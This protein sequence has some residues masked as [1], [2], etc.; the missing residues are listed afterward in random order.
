MRSLLRKTKELLNRREPFVLVVVTE[1]KGSAPRDAGAAMIVT[2]NGLFEG[3]VGGGAIE[4]HC[5]E[6]AKELLREEKSDRAHYTL[7]KDSAKDIGMICGGENRV[8]FQYFSP[9]EGEMLRNFSDDHVAMALFLDGTTPLLVSAGDA[10]LH[11]NSYNRV[12]RDGYREVFLWDLRKPP[13]AFVFGGGHVSRAVVPLLHFLNFR[14][15]VL[16]NRPEFL[17]EEDLPLAEE[18]MLV[19]YDNLPKLPMGSE[20][21][22]IILTRGHESDGQVLRQCFSYDPTYIGMIG[23][24]RKSGALFRALR[25]EGVSEEQIEKVHT[26]VGLDIGAETPEEIAVSIVAEIIQ[27]KEKK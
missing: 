24:K 9:K 13:K 17:L 22:V 26:P 10:L 20:D 12:V 5:I 7:S 3:T 15:H 4:Y 8:L 18:R 2:K 25:E 14:V 6:R 1:K 11:R 19:E 21:Y 23:S 27:N 16:E